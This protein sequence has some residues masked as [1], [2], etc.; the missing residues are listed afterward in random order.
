MNADKMGVNMQKI[1]KIDKKWRS[2]KIREIG[3]T[4]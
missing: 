4:Y 3:I 1:H 2:W